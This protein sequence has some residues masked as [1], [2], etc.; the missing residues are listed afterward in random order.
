MKDNP[1]L[2]ELLLEAKNHRLMVSWN[3]QL[4]EP[5]QTR[6]KKNQELEMHVYQVPGGW[7]GCMSLEVT[8]DT[9][10]EKTYSKLGKYP[11]QIW[12]RITIFIM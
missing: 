3:L 2:A 12:Q 1:G 11:Q 8:E 6:K 9:T 4:I 5:D 7:G 10:K